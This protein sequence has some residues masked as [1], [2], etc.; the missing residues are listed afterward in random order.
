M[1][2]SD[3][4]GKWTEKMA[5]EQQLMTLNDEIDQLKTENKKLRQA[6][7]NKDAENAARDKEIK[8]LEQE[9]K[10]LIKVSS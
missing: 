5:S 7:E 2:L 6:A 3:E 4:A 8:N 1:C 10:S 9:I